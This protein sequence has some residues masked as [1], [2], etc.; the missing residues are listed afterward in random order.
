MQRF[1]ALRQEFRTDLLGMSEDVKV[2]SKR[3][4]TADRRRF[5]RMAAR[6]AAA[7]D[8]KAPAEDLSSL[9][10]RLNMDEGGVSGSAA[11]HGRASSSQRPFWTPPDAA[12][13][14]REKR[15]QA[16]VDR[17]TG[18]AGAELR[19]QINKAGSML[20]SLA[21]QAAR[22]GDGGVGGLEGLWAA[23]SVRGAA[24]GSWG[25]GG[26]GGKDAAADAEVGV[27]DPTLGRPLTPKQRADAAEFL[28]SQAKEAALFRGGSS[29]GISQED[30]AQTAARSNTEGRRRKRAAGAVAI[31]GAGEDDFVSFTRM[32]DGSGRV[33]GA[34]PP[35]PPPAAAVPAGAWAAKAGGSGSGGLGSKR[36]QPPPQQQQQ[37]QQQRQSGPGGGRSASAAQ[38]SPSSPSPSSSSSPSSL[39]LSTLHAMCTALGIDPYNVTPDALG[40]GGGSGGGG[41]DSEEEGEEEDVERSRRKKGKRHHPAWEAALAAVDLEEEGGSLPAHHARTGALLTDRQRRG[42]ALARAVLSYFPRG[43][44]DDDGS[45]GAARGGSGGAFSWH[46]LSGRGLTVESVLRAAGLTPADLG[47]GGGDGDDEEE[48]EEGGAVDARIRARIRAVL[49]AEAA[50]GRKLKK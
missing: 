15:R 42:L 6:A 45:E 50:A 11:G 20:T 31:D 44:S 48:D 27:R 30:A 23:P 7:A 3:L 4:S 32:E 36:T 49:V 14:P 33:A 18:P 26:E 24:A 16:A 40:V 8:G 35:T 47:E 5:R 43:G 37:Q 29:G 9:E 17:A 12:A 46:E 39:P 2:F 10:D 38:P 25:P 22:A 34:A 19:S 41:W 21:Q 13:S 1:E 28:A